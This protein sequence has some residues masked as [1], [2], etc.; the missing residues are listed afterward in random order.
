MNDSLMDLALATDD[1]WRRFRHELADRMADLHPDELVEVVG[2]SMINDRGLESTP[3]FE[4]SRDGEVVFGRVT[5]DC[6][7]AK[8]GVAKKARRHLVT[9]G[10]DKDKSPYDVTEFRA[11]VDVSHVDVLAAMTVA[12]LREVFEVAHPASLSGDVTVDDDDPEFTDGTGGCL[13]TGPLAVFPTSHHDLDELIDEALS[14]VLGYVP[15]RD[16]DGD[17][18]MPCG[19]SV[20]YVSSL[21]TGSAIRVWALLAWQIT[22]LDRARF[23]VEVLNRDHPLARFALVGDRITAEM[24]LLSSPF[25]PEH[26]RTTFRLLRDLADEVDGDLAVRVSGRRYSDSG[27][28]DVDDTSAADV[29][30]ETHDEN[31][32]SMMTLLQLDADRPRSISPAMAAHICGNDPERLLRL[33]TSEEEQEIEWLNA[34]DEARGDD[35]SEEL[36]EVC[37]DER[38]HAE[39]T[40]KLLRRALRHVVDGEFHRSSA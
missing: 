30:E 37:E 32:T 8:A 33:I 23:E 40:V 22:D 29:E 35:D 34:R 19:T 38:A 5:G 21:P 1:A 3:C 31:H 26:L 16:E 7:H 11:E 39:R 9:I 13:T 15:G 24:H 20:V 10:W 18:V 14:C 28:E 36:A 12:A 4:F 17:V 2:E 25:V 27:E 6:V